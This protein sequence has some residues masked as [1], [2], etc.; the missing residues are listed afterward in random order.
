MLE[1]TNN[2]QV[3][4]SNNKPI[5]PE[6]QSICGMV[7]AELVATFLSMGYSKNV[8][9]K[10]L[11]M[12]NNNFD[13]AMEWI[14]CNQTEKDFEEELRIIQPGQEKPKMSDEEA[15][16]KAKELQEKA[17]KIIKE[18][19]EESQRVGALKRIEESI[20]FK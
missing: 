3:K 11:F 8:S 4:N 13:T 18:K 5:E 14:Y 20:Y 12:N 1:E 10:A 17:R 15:Y 6:G 16:Q 9:E 2:T 19:E 7:N